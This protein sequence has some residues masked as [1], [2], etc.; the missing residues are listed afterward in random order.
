MTACTLVDPADLGRDEVLALYDSV[1][2]TAYTDVPDTLLRALAGSHRIAV[3]R[4]DGN[5]VGLARSVSDGATLVYL[6]DILVHPDHHRSGY[7]RE[8]VGTLLAEY[9][10]IR[11]QVLITDA[12]PGQRAFYEA[13]GF[14]EA[15]DMERGTRAFLRFS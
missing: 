4:A 6:Q 1:G 15:H 7:G 2:W 5:L 9:A 13:L 11:Q 8:L 14:T 3:A 12:E 10:G